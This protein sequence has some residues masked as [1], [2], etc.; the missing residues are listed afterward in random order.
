MNLRIHY[1]TVRYGQFFPDDPK[2]YYRALYR[3]EGKEVEITVRRKRKKRSGRENRY[4]W[5]VIVDILANHLGYTPQEM[6]EALKWEL[7]RIR[8][9]GKPDTVKSTADLST[10][11]FED[12]CSRARMWAS[13]ELGCYIPL[14]NEVDYD[15]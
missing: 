12:Y 14:P 9:R 8:H 15:Y 2:K 13:A 5:A 10:V 1:G 11:E 3:N 7:L 6:H 4:Y